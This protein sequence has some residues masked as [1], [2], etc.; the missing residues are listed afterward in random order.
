[1]ILSRWLF[2]WCVLSSCLLPAQVAWQRLGSGT[3]Y[4]GSSVVFDTQHQRFLAVEHSTVLIKEWNGS[5]WQPIAASPY[6]HMT[7][8]PYACYDTLRQRVV[9]AG[10]QISG[11]AGLSILEWDGAIWSLRTPPQWNVAPNNCVWDPVR[12]KSLVAGNLLYEWDGTTLTNL[13]APPNSTYGLSFNAMAGR[14]MLTGVPCRELRLDNTW[15]AMP[16]TVQ[17]VHMGFTFYDPATNLVHS[18]PPAGWGYQPEVWDGTQWRTVNAGTIDTG[19]QNMLRVAIDPATNEILAA[20]NYG[21]FRLVRGPLG[22]VT[23]RGT[24]CPGAFGVPSVVPLSN[25]LPV[26]V[27]GKTMGF[28]ATNILPNPYG[29]SYLIF[30]FDAAQWNGYPLPLD[31]AVFGMPGCRLYQSIDAFHAPWGGSMTLSFPGQVGLL[32]VTFHVQ[33]MGLELY[34]ANG[35]GTCMSPSYQC[36]IGI[37]W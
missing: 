8:A 16:P 33:A 13:G 21:T 23:V 36:S 11:I 28:Q 24:G 5:A 6:A 19:W 26:P 37:G 15:V 25:H 31:T 10:V 4:A 2:P 30:G 18:M 27:V 35:P 20:D 3:Q 1:M 22:S 12:Q 7:A 29:I 17:G 32:G 34:G 9:I 14:P